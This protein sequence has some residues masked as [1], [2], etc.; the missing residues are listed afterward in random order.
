MD[1][2]DDDVALH[3]QETIEANLSL[4]RAAE[5]ERDGALAAETSASGFMVPSASG[6]MVPSAS[7]FMV[8]S[9]SGFM[10]P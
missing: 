10:V 8:P 5:H 4:E 2:K 9:A 3:D 1:N 6:F 7:G